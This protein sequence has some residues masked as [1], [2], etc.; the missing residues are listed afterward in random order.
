MKRKHRDKLMGLPEVILL[1]TMIFQIALAAVYYVYMYSGAYAVKLIKEGNYSQAAKIIDSKHIGSAKKIQSWI[2]NYLYDELGVYSDTVDSDKAKELLGLIDSFE[3]QKYDCGTPLYD[4]Y[5]TEL[6]RHNY[7]SGDICALNMAQKMIDSGD[8]L[9][10]DDVIKDEIIRYEQDHFLELVN[11]QRLGNG[12]PALEGSQELN[13]VCHRMAIEGMAGSEDFSGISDMN[14]SYGVK[15]S[16]VTF[17]HLYPCDT[18]EDFIDSLSD[19]SAS[20]LFEN[21]EYTKLG[22]NL[23]FD[24][25]EMSFYWFVEIISE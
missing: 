18:T 17:W 14:E 24:E 23:I 25:E 20:T 7:I 19:K 12:L 21:S 13:S 6:N 11:S 10:I 8:D 22:V 4:R 16:K 15:A 9:D 3:K 2:K 1:L 5:R